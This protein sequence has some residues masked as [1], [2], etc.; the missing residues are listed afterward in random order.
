[1]LETCFVHVT[2]VCEILLT[3]GVLDELVPL[4]P[5][6]RINRF[7]VVGVVPIVIE[8]DVGGGLLPVAL[9]WFDDELQL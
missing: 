4:P 3:E 2:P 7:P 1:V 9:P 5:K 8:R 6:T